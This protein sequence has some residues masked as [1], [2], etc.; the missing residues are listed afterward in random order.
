MLVRLVDGTLSNKCPVTIADS[1]W[2][3][4]AATL[5]NFFPKSY[6]IRKIVTILETLPDSSNIL[7]PPLITSSRYPRNPISLKQE[8]KR[9][10]AL[11]SS[12]AKPG[13]L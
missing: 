5:L 12:F 4:K 7:H 2:Y 9:H 11:Y 8:A 10:E 13:I 6:D 1:E 3:M